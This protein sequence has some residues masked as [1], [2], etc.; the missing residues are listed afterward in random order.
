VGYPLIRSP[1]PELGRSKLRSIK[2]NS[3]MNEKPDKETNR[4]LFHIILGL[5]SILLLLHFGRGFMTDAVFFVIIIGTLLMNAKIGGAKIFL[6][7]WFEKMFE[8]SDAILPG[9]G[10]AAYAVGV[11]IALTFLADL[12]LIV[13]VVYILAV[14]DG[15]S[16]IVGRLGRMK[17]PYNQR[18][19]VEGSLALFVSSL[20][21]YL[22]IGPLIIPLAIVAAVAESIPGLEDNITIPIACTA[23]L[24]II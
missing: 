8:R 22:L 6:V 13:S 1:I 7:E 14:G 16:T 20:P 4:Q 9:W 3:G 24:L 10:S 11:L 19:T 5:F 17:L 15:I 21:A 18:K 2:P 23:F 12:S